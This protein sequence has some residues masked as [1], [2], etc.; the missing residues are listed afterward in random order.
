MEGKGGA[1]CADGG[2]SADDG[3]GPFRYI[4]PHDECEQHKDVVEREWADVLAY[5]SCG[6]ADAKTS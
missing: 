4:T 6:L 1:G 5:L 2:S 3:T